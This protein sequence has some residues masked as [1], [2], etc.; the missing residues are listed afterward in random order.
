VPRPAFRAELRSHILS[1]EIAR[2]GDA[3]YWCLAESLIGGTDN[4]W[5]GGRRLSWPVVDA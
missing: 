2:R 1:A 5:M 3:Y 4:T